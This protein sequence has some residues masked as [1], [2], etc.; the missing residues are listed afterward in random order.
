MHNMESLTLAA[1]LAFMVTV[2][3]CDFR[4]RRIPN[5]LNLAG[6]VVGLGLQGATGGW[7]SFFA[8]VSGF[9]LGFAILSVPYLAGM[10]GAG[11]VKFV[12]AAGA[13]LGARLLLVGLAVGIVVGGVVGAVSLIRHGRFVPALR[14]L[15][16]D[17]LCLASGVRPAKLKHVDSVE[18]IPY[19]VML[20]MGLAVSVAHAFLKEGP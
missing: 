15:L 20:A 3:V 6:L 1:A 13:F 19:G 11:D 2:A 8:G 17:L 5:V 16:A 14:G 9:A 18:T 4:A 12:A 7:E 10:V